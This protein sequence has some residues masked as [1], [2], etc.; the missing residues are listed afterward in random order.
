MAS[1]RRKELIKRLLHYRSFVMGIIIISIFISLMIYMNFVFPYPEAEAAWNDPQ[2]WRDYPKGAPPAWIKYFTGRKEI[3]GTLI[4]DTRTVNPRLLYKTK[5]TVGGISIIH[6]EMTIPYDYDVFPSEV[7]LYLS[8]I[9]ENIT[10]EV[11]SVGVR[12]IKWVKP[13]NITLVLFSGHVPARENFLIEL[14]KPGEELPKILRDYRVIIRSLYNTTLA[15][16]LSAIQ[17]LFVDDEALIT[18]NETIP[19]K[20]SYKIIYEYI[21]DPEITSIELRILAKG[22]VY[23]IFG[24]DAKGRDLFVG[25]AWGIPFAISFGLTASILT[26]LLIMMIAA[27][28]A[29]Y[30]SWVDLLTSRL[31]ETFM[32][33]P[34]LPTLMMLIAFDPTGFQLWKLLVFTICFSV[35]SS[36][37]LKSQRALFLQIREMPYIE[38]A[39]AYGASSIRIIFRYMVPRVIPMII[40]GIVISVPNFVFL[41]AALALFGIT[42]PKAIT[43]GKILNEAYSRAALIIG[44]WHWMFAPAL[45]LFMLSI[46]FASIGFTLDRVFNPKLRQL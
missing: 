13:S 39:R 3:E 30:K 22:T 26:S 37:G 18:R 31:N 16:N 27:T 8:V 17:I 7:E 35:L 23:G 15:I 28:A 44:Y 1:R 12:T 4:Y 14:Q 21:E 41:E 6:V 25:V 20:G 36:G 33:L 24:T 19:L 11:K 42:D 2:Y 43:W 32:I 5:E 9:R 46:A 10:G 38:A 40:P 45:A 34:F 29:W